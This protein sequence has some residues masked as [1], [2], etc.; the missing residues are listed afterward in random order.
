MHWD[1]QSDVGQEF[2]GVSRA[3]QKLILCVHASTLSEL[4]ATRPE[5]V[6]LFGEPIPMPSGA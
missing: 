4:H 6:V 5:F 1:V 2:V 3:K